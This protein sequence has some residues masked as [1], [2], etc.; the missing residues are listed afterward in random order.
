MEEK[1]DY[2][3]ETPQAINEEFD[4]V[5]FDEKTD[6]KPKDDTEAM[7]YTIDNMSLEELKQKREILIRM[8]E[9][10]K[11]KARQQEDNDYSITF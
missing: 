4:Y 10:E 7:D 1:F 9:E 2:V 5:G 3:G 11:N 6:K 8:K